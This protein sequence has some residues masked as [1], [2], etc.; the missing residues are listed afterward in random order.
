MLAGKLVRHRVLHCFELLSQ[1]RHKPLLRH[2]ILEGLSHE[3]DNSLRVHLRSAT[4]EMLD[5]LNVAPQLDE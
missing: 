1:L 4:V 3:R 2:Y 5:L